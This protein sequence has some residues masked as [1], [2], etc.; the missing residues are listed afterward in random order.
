LIR[1]KS[2]QNL[3]VLEVEAEEDKEEEEYRAKRR[4]TII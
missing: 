4:R 1:G 2:L 3:Q